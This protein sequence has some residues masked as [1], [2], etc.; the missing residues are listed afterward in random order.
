MLGALI[1]IIYAGS[2]KQ[3][4]VPVQQRLI[5]LILSV[6]LSLFNLANIIKDLFNRLPNIDK[7]IISIHCHN[8]LGMAV[9]NFITAIQAGAR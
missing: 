3:Q 7:A 2:W 9:A 6:T 1:P 5:S 4:S 8:D